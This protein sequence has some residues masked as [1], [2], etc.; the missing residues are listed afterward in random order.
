LCLLDL[1]QGV[2]REKTVATA[3]PI[4]YR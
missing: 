1:R 2:S 4:G 3:G